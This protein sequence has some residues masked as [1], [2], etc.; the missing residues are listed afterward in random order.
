MKPCLLHHPH[1]G[2]HKL[3]RERE[4]R[5][6]AHRVGLAEE[7]LAEE[8]EGAGFEEVR[9]A[10]VPV[11]ILLNDPVQNLQLSRVELRTN[12]S[13]EFAHGAATAAGKS[14][15]LRKVL[16]WHVFSYTTQVQVQVQNIA[17]AQGAYAIV[18][19]SD[20]ARE[21]GGAVNALLP[22]RIEARED[23]LHCHREAAEF[24]EIVQRNARGRRVGQQSHH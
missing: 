14:L 1:A 7:G 4:E 23:G 17:N 11:R 18:E 16:C 3:S 6:L 19:G 13:S 5:E 24:Q 8:H 10:H 2:T 20:E 21:V 15:S 12:V 9:G 22:R